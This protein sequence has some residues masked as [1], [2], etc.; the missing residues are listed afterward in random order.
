[1][2]EFKVAFSNLTFS[3]CFNCSDVAK[4]SKRT[5]RSA[6]KVAHVSP[7]PTV[8]AGILLLCLSCPEKQK[9]GLIVIIREVLSAFQA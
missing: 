7:P 1:M 6:M 8:P 3:I 5:V 2:K 9:V 4:P